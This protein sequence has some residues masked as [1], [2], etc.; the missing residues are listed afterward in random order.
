MARVWQKHTLPELLVRKMAHR[1]GLRFRIH[2][3]DLPGSS[4]L[5]FPKYGLAL[6]VHGCFWHQ[7]HGCRRCTMPRSN[8]AYWRE[9]FESNKARDARSVR[10]LRRIGWRSRVVWECEALDP[11][12]LK[13]R[14]KQIFGRSARTS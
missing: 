14:L 9:K 5:L 11:R 1:M 8:E 6:F 10:E 3:A 13:R 4:D 12:I 2:R 7:H